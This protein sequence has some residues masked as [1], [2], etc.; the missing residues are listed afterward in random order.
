MTSKKQ[1]INV[2]QKH[3]MRESFMERNSHS[4]KYRKTKEWFRWVT[5]VNPE[6]IKAESIIAVFNE[7]GD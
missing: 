7:L 3:H 1:K 2:A 4:K 6:N 5:V